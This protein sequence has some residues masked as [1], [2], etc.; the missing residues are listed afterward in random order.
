MPSKQVFGLDVLHYD[1]HFDRL[2]DLL[3]VRTLW[4][5]DPSA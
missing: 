2:G 4:I 3:G 1:H 5:A